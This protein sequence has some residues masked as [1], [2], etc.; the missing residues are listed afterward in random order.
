MY[1]PSKRV[2]LIGIVVGVTALASLALA[3]S[4]PA[5]VG[6][7]HQDCRAMDL[8]AERL[9]NAPDGSVRL[10]YGE[11]PQ[12]A[13]IPGPLIVLTEGECINI[14]LTNDVPN[15]TLKKLAKQYGMPSDYPLAVSIHPHGVKYSITSDG[16]WHTDSY[17]LSGQS[18]TYTWT[19]VPGETAGYWW[20]HDH[21]VGTDHGSGGLASG[22]WGG[23]IVRR[24]GDLV[25][26]RPT[27]VVAMG[28]DA[29]INLEHDPLTPRFVAT[30]GQR[31]EF[32][33]FD[34]GNSVHTFHLHA[35]SW[36]DDR[37]GIID[38]TDPNQR[39]IDDKVLGPGDSFGFQVIAGQDVGPGQWMYHC[40]IQAH[41]D[42]GMR[43]IFHVLP[44]NATL[45][46]GPTEP[47]GSDMDMDMEE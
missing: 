47:P 38:P 15:Q 8:F 31:V 39:I 7:I 41:S 23:L 16:T 44:A 11:T 13:S 24:P 42:A 45:P 33:I 10:G 18:R 37:T 28:D 4:P 21:M 32:L 34:W 9:P 26:D 36:A 29:T 27:F 3:G 19:A 17:V 43:G 2:R 1:R 12:T 22:L 5:A 46:V 6:G 25:P 14:T 20:Y 40:H 30:E 35:H